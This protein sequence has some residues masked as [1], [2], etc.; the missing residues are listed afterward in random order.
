[1]K[2]VITGLVLIYLLLLSFYTLANFNLIN[3]AIF[4]MTVIGYG[5]YIDSDLKRMNEKEQAGK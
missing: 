5:L 2:I 3:F 1:M 4:V